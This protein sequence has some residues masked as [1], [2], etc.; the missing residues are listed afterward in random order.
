MPNKEIKGFFF[1]AVVLVLLVMISI[2]SLA[3][4]P[5]T[6]LEGKTLTFY[7]DN[8]KSARSGIV[9]VIEE[10]YSKSNKPA[11][12]GKDDY[13]DITKI[14]IDPSFANYC[15]HSTAYWFANLGNAESIEG[16]N[17]LN[18]SEV[19]DMTSMFKDCR[20]L[21]VIDC[22]NFNTEK[23]QST[24][25]MFED[26]KSITTLDLSHFNTANVKDMG[27]MFVGC[28]KLQSLDL[29]NFNTECVTKMGS[30][31]ENCESLTSI[32][33]SSFNTSDVVD[34]SY[35]FESCE[36]LASLDLSKLNTEKVTNM[37][38]MF[39]YCKALKTLDLS[40][41]NTENV[42]EIVHMF[43]NCIALETIYVSTEWSVQNISSGHEVFEGC[44][45]LIGG[46]GTQWDE[47]H[48]DYDYAHID[49]G[50][51]NPGYLTYKGHSG[52]TGI[53]TLHKP[54][55]SKNALYS[56]GGIRLPKE[57]VNG[58]IIQNGRKRLVQK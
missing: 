45:N 25:D 16:M 53:Y 41:F 24:Y 39:G 10:V 37:T 9:Y 34:M 36:A 17:Y 49:G 33:L 26:C 11:W 46:N 14:V 29:A 7:Y 52:K 35:M 56:I 42:S 40:G 31:F 51:S 48:I 4:E 5:Y 1:H 23:V 57:S 55:T 3:A 8:S 58:I 19:T 38:Y 50:E 30:M 12:M 27:F 21:T 47:N 15:P 6:V 54:Y 28:K 18:T 2:S 32:N 22:S 13:P 20:N 44:S 43:S